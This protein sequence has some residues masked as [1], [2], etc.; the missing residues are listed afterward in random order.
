[1]QWRRF[2]ARLL[3]VILIRVFFTFVISELLYWHFSPSFVVTWLV[4]MSIFAIQILVEPLFLSKFG[5]TPGKWLLGL[6]V[7]DEDGHNLSYRAAQKRFW[8]VFQY[9][10]GFNVPLFNLYRFYQSYK[11]ISDNKPLPWEQEVVYTPEG[12]RTKS[13]HCVC[14]RKSGTRV[15]LFIMVNVLCIALLSIMQIRTVFPKYRGVVTT[16]MYVQNIN[17]LLSRPDFIECG[18]RMTPDGRWE[19]DLSLSEKEMSGRFN[20]NLVPHT[21]YENGG[22]LEKVVL[23][24]DSF[25]IFMPSLMMQSFYLADKDTHTFAV[26]D[27]KLKAFTLSVPDNTYE[28]NG[29][30]FSVKMVED[31]VLYEV[32]KMY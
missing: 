30:R 2:L 26:L 3:D 29:Y 23:H 16:E 19:V 4:L 14:H 15:A 6:Y 21:F 9:G 10:Y 5:T 20:L 22:K 7:T 27:Q 13:N 32:E 1:M 25:D 24:T 17:T 8:L 12:W 11:T 18:Y 28:V 31:G